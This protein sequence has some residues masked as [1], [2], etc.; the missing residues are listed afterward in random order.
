VSCPCVNQ[1]LPNRSSKCSP[2]NYALQS[3]YYSCS[4]S[5]SSQNCRLI[6]SLEQQR[7]TK[8]TNSRQRA[9]SHSSRRSSSTLRSRTA[10]RARRRASVRRSSNLNAVTS[11]SL[12]TSARAGSHGGRDDGR[13]CSTRLTPTPRS[14]RRIARPARACPAAPRARRAIAA[15]PPGGPGTGGPGT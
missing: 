5:L 6:N 8:H 10:R 13:S 14:P 4:F 3:C 1:K 12:H 11:R 2:P 9:S 15:A 7:R